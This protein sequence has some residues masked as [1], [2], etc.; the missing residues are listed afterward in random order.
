MEG[1]ARSRAFWWTLLTIAA[2]VIVASFV[3]EALDGFGHVGLWFTMF[4]SACTVIVSLGNLRNLSRARTE[5]R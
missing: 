4:G 3:L 2:S 5:D 1:L